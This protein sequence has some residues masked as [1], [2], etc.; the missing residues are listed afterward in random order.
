MTILNSS[1]YLN[2][3]SATAASCTISL[4]ML[5]ARLQMLQQLIGSVSCRCW[6]GAGC[7]CAFFYYIPRGQYIY[8]RS[9]AATTFW[10]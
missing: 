7:D 3:N 2:G 9:K 5:K 8:A 4:D 1:L 6:F 10:R